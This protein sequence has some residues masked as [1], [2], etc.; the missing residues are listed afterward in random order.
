[1]CEKGK[2]RAI[3]DLNAPNGSPGIPFQSQGFEQDGSC[4]FIRF[5]PYFHLNMTS[6]IQSCKTMEKLK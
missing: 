6:Q 1:M 3:T 2:K 5:R 4:H